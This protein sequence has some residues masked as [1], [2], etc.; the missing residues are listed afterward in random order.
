MGEV[1]RICVDRRTLDDLIKSSETITRLFGVRLVLPEQR[2][3][4]EQQRTSGVSGQ[5][6]LQDNENFT[7]NV[8]STSYSRRGRNENQVVVPLEIVLR[9]TLST[10][11]SFSAVG[12]TGG[13]LWCGGGYTNNSGS[14]NVTSG[15]GEQT[16]T[17]EDQTVDVSTNRSIFEIAARVQV[18]F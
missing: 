17:H 15:G 2:E 12:E 16:I 10:G 8:S 7:E 14:C 13:A 6:G 1:P 11:R 5:V 3:F 4:N 9:D 18:N